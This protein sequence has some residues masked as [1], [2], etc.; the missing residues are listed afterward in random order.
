MVMKHMV[1]DY[2]PLGFRV[3][4]CAY[5]TKRPLISDWAKFASND[6]DQI[7]AW[8]KAWPRANWAVLTGRMSGVI[9]IDV[10][11]ES[12]WNWLLKTHG[13]Q[14]APICRT[15]KGYHVYYQ[16]PLELPLR[17][18]VTLSDARIELRGNNHLC[19]LPPSQHPVFDIVYAWLPGYKPEGP[20][21]FPPA[22]EWVVEA[23]KPVERKAYVP[24]TEPI[25][26]R[27]VQAAMA[28]ELA[29]LEG[30]PE[31]SRNHT[32]YRVA[33]KL[34]RFGQEYVGNIERELTSVALNIG[35]S[36]QEIANTLQ[37]AAKAR[38]VTL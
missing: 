12:A 26:D 15:G 17:S 30:T 2:L 16:Y 32:L 10:E 13:H 5:A 8:L 11:G 35:L 1:F 38:G 6:R 18:Q 28:A 14:L 7:M 9:V 21:P 19:L 24:N 33:F 4:P 20:I 36:Q 34:L 3:V 37:S 25:N 22:P 23:M 29:D 31:G 27:Y